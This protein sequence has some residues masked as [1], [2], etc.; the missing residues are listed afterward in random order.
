MCGILVELGKDI[1]IGLISGALSSWEI[2]ALWQKKMD[3]KEKDHQDEVA[4]REYT[5]SYYDT[6]QRLCRFL[7]RL[8][9]ELG[10]KN[11]S[12]KADNIRRL[13]DAQPSTPVFVDAL[14]EEGKKEMATLFTLKRNLDE[15]AKSG[16]LSDE[17]S[18]MYKRKIF[19]FECQFLKK[20]SE[21]LKPYEKLSKD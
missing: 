21:Y 13:L 16:L 5:S 18:E 19:Q 15:D 8:Q 7:E 12:E 3:A 17:K 2:T 10:F 9:L 4:K 11:S 20:Q 6:V 14:T 1:L